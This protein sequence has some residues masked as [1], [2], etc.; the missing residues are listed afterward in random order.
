MLIPFIVIGAAGGAA[1][2]WVGQGRARWVRW[3]F[4]M[5]LVGLVSALTLLPVAQR[6]AAKRH[7]VKNHDV[8]AEGIMR[9]N[10]KGTLA[11][12]QVAFPASPRQSLTDDCGPEVRAGLFGCPTSLT[13]PVGILT[14]PDG[15]LLHKRSDPIHFR[16]ISVSAVEPDCS[17]GIFCLTQEKIDQWCGELRPDQAESIWCRDKPPMRFSLRTATTPGQSD[18]DEPELTAR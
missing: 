11:K 7:A 1:V 8:R 13:N 6:E 17:L 2:L 4:G 16:S 15:V 10:F 9:A 12:H 3:A 5:E 18:C 14:K